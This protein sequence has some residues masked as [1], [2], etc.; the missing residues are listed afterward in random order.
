MA[1][2]HESGLGA[3]LKRAQDLI[4]YLNGF[5]NYNPPRPEES[6]AQLTTLTGSIAAANAAADGQR[7][8]YRLAVDDRQKIFRD[9]ESSVLKVLSPLRGAVEAQYGKESKQT[10]IIS[11]L[12]RGMR[13][14][15]ITKS[16][17]DPANDKAVST[18]QQSYGSM[19]QQ[20]SHIVSALQSF[21]NY[22]PS[23]ASL[24]IAALEQKIQSIDTINNTIATSI[25]QL[26]VN[27]SN[28]TALYEDLG[29]RA[30]RVKSYIR[31]EYGN[32]SQEYRLIKGLSI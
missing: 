16:P 8:I 23:N 6:I 7:E 4:T 31:A 12:V 3:K 15:K 21:G 30:Q 19:A 9:D 27:R 29:E 20:F 1:T 26:S 14:S 25:Q 18:S 13:S 5:S 24:K 2:Q 10:T 32:Q 22:D 11:G 17:A 28:R